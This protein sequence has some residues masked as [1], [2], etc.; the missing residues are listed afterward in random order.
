MKRVFLLLILCLFAACGAEVEKSLLETKTEDMQQ[1]VQQKGQ[2]I[3][4]V[5]LESGSTEEKTDYISPIDFNV[6]QS[7]NP[8][9]YAWLHIPKAEISYPVLQHSEDDSF[10]L[11][12]DSEGNEKQA[13]AL[14]TE[15]TYNSMDFNDPV[16]IIYGHRMNTGTMFSN[17]Q[18]FYSNPENFRQHKGITLFLPDRQLNYEVF[19][20]VV[21][22]D[23][24]ILDNYDFHRA[25]VY[26]AFFESVF[27]IRAFNSNVDMNCELDYDSKILVLSTCLQGDYSQ[28][29]LVFAK[30]IE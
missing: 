14:F 16:T 6:L 7:T 8:D 20:A 19:A 18:P 9:I 28:R 29:Y 11:T 27:D 13:G 23:R 26:Q 25:R 5:P 3:Q 22:D 17:L 4:R 2:S 21:Y 10:Y 30:Q 15:H 1:N 12:H 24:H